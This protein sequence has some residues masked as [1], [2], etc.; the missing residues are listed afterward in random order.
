VHQLKII[1]LSSLLFTCVLKSNAQSF[2]T[3]SDSVSNKRITLV[4]SGLTSGWAGSILG[5]KYVWY[6]NFEQSKFHFFNDAREWGY[7]DKLGHITT[8]WNIS[9]ATGEFYHWAGLKRKNAALIGG[10]FG[11]A[12]LTTFELLDAYSEEWG[13]SW[14]DMLANTAGSALYTVQE[15]IWGK[16][17][18]KLKFSAQNSGLSELRPEVLGSDFLSR[19]F[20]DYNGQTY[21]VTGHP[22]NLLQDKVIIP[23]WI[24]LAIGYS[25]NNQLYGDGSSLIIQ[26]GNA[27]EVYH[28]YRQLFISLDLDLEELPVKSKLLKLLLRGVNII[29]VPMPAIQFSNNG[30]RFHALYF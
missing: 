25:I 23:K 18:L 19:T 16:Q 3:P 21:W 13:F 1:V 22:F 9:R 4:T 11:L 15:L 12:Y 26:N 28:P 5:L 7:M 29:K 24:T 27:Q 8:A 10:G 6:S 2:L 20:K 17:L 14:A 30:I